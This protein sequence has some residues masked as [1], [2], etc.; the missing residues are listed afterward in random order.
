MSDNA[1]GAAASAAATP[2]AAATQA[3]VGSKDAVLG[4]DDNGQPLPLKAADSVAAPAKPKPA[5]KDWDALTLPAE[6]SLSDA[7]SSGD[8]GEDKPVKEFLKELFDVATQKGL[9]GALP[10]HQKCIRGCGPN[11]EDAVRKEY[12]VLMAGH[13]GDL[14]R[15]LKRN[16]LVANLHKFKFLEDTKGRRDVYYDQY[17]SPGALWCPLEKRIPL[18]P[19]E[20]KYVHE[21]QKDEGVRPAMITLLDKMWELTHVQGET[22]INF[23]VTNRGS[24]SDIILP[25]GEG[26][27]D[28]DQHNMGSSV[29]LYLM[30]TDGPRQ[31]PTLTPER[32]YVRA[33]AVNLLDAL[34]RAAVA[35]GVHWNVYYN[36]ADVARDVNTDN[37]YVKFKG[38]DKKKWHGPGAPG[39]GVS[40]GSLILHFH[41]DVHPKKGIKEE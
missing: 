41:L 38:K 29:D 15:R 16:W 21:A 2:T 3:A 39:L 19:G 11:T 4:L 6:E 37:V 9:T 40:S 36:D 10:D 33:D 22:P 5:P 25:G 30:K 35:V 7:K 14:L 8:W 23:K 28:Q 12:A 32:F 27:G 34:K 13:Q 20:K 17:L 1:V 18:K 31:H 24:K 26:F